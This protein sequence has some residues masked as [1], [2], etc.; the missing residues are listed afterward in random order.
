MSASTSSTR[1]QVASAPVSWGVMEETDTSVWPSAERVLAEITAA[2]YDGTEL[3]PSGYF[4]TEVDALRSTL[5]THR[6]TLT[7]AF[8]PLRWFQSERLPGDI[9]VLIQVAELLAALDCPF[10]VVADG[11]AVPGESAPNESAWKKTATTMEDVAR[12]VQRLGLRLVF[13][14]EAGSHLAT[15][16]D[17][18]RLCALTDPELVGVCLD[19]GHYAYSFGNPRDAVRQYGRRIRYIHL[20][21]VDPA[22]RERVA[23]D[24]L[25]FYAAVRSGVFTPLGRGCA[26]IA[27]VVSDLLSMGYTGWL[28]TEQDV[29]MPLANGRTPLENARLSREFL[30]QLG[31]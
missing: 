5:A 17:Q 13:H 18:E 4:P 6:L 15:P 23:R 31:L 3:G 21:D 25:D 19:T 20:K 1:I 30:R 14:L 8:V 24:G 29:L 7:S 28:V 22:V 9:E 16:D 26:E 10:I 12:R 27:A 2:G 11:M